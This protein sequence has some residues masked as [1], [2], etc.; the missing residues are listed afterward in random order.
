MEDIVNALNP[1][2]QQQRK[3]FLTKNT[4]TLHLH[5]ITLDTFTL[6]LHRITLDTF[7]LRLHRITLHT[8][9]GKW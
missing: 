1:T 9:T 6:Q 4:I 8:F 7:T 5:R 3:T 2:I